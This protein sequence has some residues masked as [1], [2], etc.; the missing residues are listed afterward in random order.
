MEEESCQGAE[1]MIESKWQR[2]LKWLMKK[3]PPEKKIKEYRR[4]S[5]F[6]AYV[7]I[8]CLALGF[9]NFVSLVQSFRVSQ[10]ASV[11]DMIKSWNSVLFLTGFSATCSLFGFVGLYLL[12]VAFFYSLKSLEV[13]MQRLEEWKE[14][15]T[16]K[17]AELLE[18]PAIK[19]V[20]ENLEEKK[21]NQNDEG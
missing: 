15:Q 14:F 16:K 10:V 13:K 20:L 2:F 21:R 17:V 9:L 6:Y 11:E 4:L 3:T 7:A 19:R 8:F 12:N 1:D 18:K 5:A